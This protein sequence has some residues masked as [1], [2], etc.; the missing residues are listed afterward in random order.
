MRIAELVAERLV[1]HSG[2]NRS[3]H[4]AADLDLCSKQRYLRTRVWH[5]PPALSHPLE[6]RFTSTATDYAG[7]A[8]RYHP[9]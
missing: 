1:V 5:T 4:R 9:P 7:P 2:S 8:L 6:L 3:G